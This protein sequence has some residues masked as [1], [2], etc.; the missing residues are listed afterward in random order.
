MIN[1]HHSGCKAQEAALREGDINQD[2]DLAHGMDGKRSHAGAND[3]CCHRTLSILY[4]MQDALG[5]PL[6]LGEDV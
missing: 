6:S 2:A 3:V 5:R 1:T 4:S